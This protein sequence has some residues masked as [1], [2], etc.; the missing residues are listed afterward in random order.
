MLSLCSDATDGI[1]CDDYAGAGRVIYLGTASDLVAL[2]KKVKEFKVPYSFQIQ[3]VTFVNITG[4][5]W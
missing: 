1:L 2:S 5:L 4:V 3:D